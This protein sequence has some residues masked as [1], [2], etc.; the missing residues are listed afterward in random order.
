MGCVPNWHI[1]S[2]AVP[3][4]KTL[5]EVVLK[6]EW[7]TKKC[8]PKKIKRREDSRNPQG[9]NPSIT[10]QPDVD[11]SQLWNDSE[12]WINRKMKPPATHLGSRDVWWHLMGLWDHFNHTLPIFLIND[13][14]VNSMVS[15]HISP[16]FHRK[17]DGFQWRFSQSNQSNPPNVCKVSSP[18]S[19]YRFSSPTM[20]TETRRLGACNG[21]MGFPEILSEWWL[22]GN[23]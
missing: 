13:F 5:L 11:Q 17:I 16:I 12:S 21:R 18:R 6:N 14:T 1:H 9:M 19:W 10:Q 15:C 22:Y 23:N 7:F 3:F 8:P 4:S 20:W 2:W